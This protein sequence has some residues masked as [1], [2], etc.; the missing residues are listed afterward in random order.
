MDWGAHDGTDINVTA[1]AV[2]ARRTGVTH[3]TIHRV[4]I[5][6]A[7]DHALPVFRF[8]SW[9]NDGFQEPRALTDGVRF[10]TGELF[11]GQLFDGPDS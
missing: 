9:R 6:R 7:G 5:R 1:P 10:G 2:D 8:T 11:S 3:A 4:S